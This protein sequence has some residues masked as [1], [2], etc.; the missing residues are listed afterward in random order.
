MLHGYLVFLTCI[1]MMLLLYDAA[2]RTHIIT[3]FPVNDARNSFLEMLVMWL[4]AW[5]LITVLVLKLY[6][7]VRELMSNNRPIS[8]L[9]TLSTFFEKLMGL[10]SNWFMKIK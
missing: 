10:R 8:L 4:R 9:P 1:F 2:R 5:L 3:N 7:S 6:C